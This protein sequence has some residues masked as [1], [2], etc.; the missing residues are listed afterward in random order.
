MAGNRA[1]TGKPWT[2]RHWL[3]F[4]VCA[5]LSVALIAVGCSSVGSSLKQVGAGVRHAPGRAYRLPAPAG[6]VSVNTAGSVT[7]TG[8]RSDHVAVTEDPSYSVT[9]P[10]TSHTSRNGTLALGY[11]CKTQLVCKVDY[12]ITVPRGIA[13]RVVSRESS[14][15]LAGL[16][17]P[18]TAQTFAGL[19]TA[20]GLASPTATL[21]STVGGVNATF[22]TAPAAVSASTTAGPI[23][24]SLPVP[25]TYQVNADAV[26]GVSTVTVPRASGAP[27][28]INAHS[29]LGS[30]TVSPSS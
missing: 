14:V 20:T 29:T 16:S 10:V 3:A 15:T 18:V 25:E 4:A 27:H 12:T 11:T 17:G 26:V 22:A 5:G 2:A 28:V 21:K 19:L 8:G 7:V 13:V 30:V 1:A 24:L 9:P 23:S 6:A